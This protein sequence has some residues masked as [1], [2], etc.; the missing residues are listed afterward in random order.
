MR[1]RAITGTA[2]LMVLLAGCSGGTSVS[3][4]SVGTDEIM[5]EPM[6]WLEGESVSASDHQDVA[7]VIEGH[8]YLVL[9]GS[10]TCPPE[11]EV[12]DAEVLDDE[13]VSITLYN[14]AEDDRVCSMDMSAHSFGIQ[15]DH[16]VSDEVDLVHGPGGLQV[17]SVEESGISTHGPVV[18]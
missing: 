2:A 12:R 13:I 18:E 6:Q 7:T 5:V 14:A 8:L 3:T 17:V 16:W 9:Y 15:T 1:V 11:P 4:E 10:S